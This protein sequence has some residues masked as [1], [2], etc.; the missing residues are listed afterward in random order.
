MR[1]HLICISD[2][3]RARERELGVMRGGERNIEGK[4][5]MEME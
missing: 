1:F 3:E 5:E 2:E 4:G